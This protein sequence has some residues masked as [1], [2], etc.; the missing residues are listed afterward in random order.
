MPMLFALLRSVAG[1]AL[2]WFYSRID[3]EGLEKIPSSTP[4]LLAVNH[5]NA[6]VDALVVAWI[7]PRRMVFTARATLFSNPV[8]SAFFRAVGVVPLIRRQDIASLQSSG[9]VKR[10]ERSFGALNAALASGRAVMI[11]PEGVTGDRPSLAPLRSGAARIALDARDSGVRRLAIVPIGLT[12]ERKDAPR[13]RVLAQVGDPIDV[14]SWARVDDVSDV[15]ALTAE[16]D[17]RLRAVTLNFETADDVVRASALASSFARLFRGV[18]SVP[19]VWR[20]HASLSDEVSITRRI[21]AARARL[22]GAP[23]DVRR[24]VDGLLLRLSRFNQTLAQHRLAIEDAEIA[25]DPTAGAGFVLREAPVFLV[26][27]PFAF[28]GWLNHWLPFTLARAIAMRRIESAA[29]PAMNTIV[30]GLGLV[31]L[32]YAAQAALVW[33]ILG[34][35]AALLYLASPPVAA[36]VN[37]YLQARLARATRRARAYFLFRRRRG[38]QDELRAELRWLRDEALSIDASLQ[39]AGQGSRRI[40]TISTS[41]PAM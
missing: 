24:R 3:V 25:L 31:L 10:N 22:A 38:L 39:P 21:E 32:F 41:G 9:D 23:D 8:F 40:D 11:F 13:T 20:P 1:I 6:L 18:E 19:P 29:D 17:R 16:I 34:P 14:D 33:A 2:R 36:D 4:V 7:S 5:P 15:A 30:N 27:G 28:W 26:A 12:F 35:L 37:F